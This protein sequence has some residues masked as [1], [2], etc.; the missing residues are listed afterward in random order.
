M[1][2]RTFRRK[3]LLNALL[4]NTIEDAT[5]HEKARGESTVGGDAVTPAYCPNCGEGLDVRV[6]G[7][8]PL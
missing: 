8:S 6:R 1:D 2:W 5:E 3:C 7:D 4:L